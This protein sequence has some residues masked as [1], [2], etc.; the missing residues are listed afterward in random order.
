MGGVGDFEK[1]EKTVST[2]S[3]LK[4]EMKERTVP[5]PIFLGEAGGGGGKGGKRRLYRYKLIL[6]RIDKSLQV[7]AIAFELMA[8]VDQSSSACTI[9]LFGNGRLCRA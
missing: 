1:I 5:H 4:K 9:R 3:P 7:C 6:I 2:P 8:S